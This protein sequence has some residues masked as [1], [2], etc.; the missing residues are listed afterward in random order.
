MA[1]PLSGKGA[2]V[3]A[4]GAALSFTGEAFTTVSANTVYQ[5]TN[6]AKRVWDRST[7]I[8]V[9][10]DAVTQAATLYTL[11]RLTG[12]ITFMADIGG[13]H[14]ITADGNYLPITQVAQGKAYTY[15]IRASNL[16]VT[17]F[18][19]TFVNRIQGCKDVSGS[20]NLWGIDTYYRDALIAGNPVVVEFWTDTT[21]VY[22]LRVW[23]LLNKEQ[24][25]TAITSAVDV[26]VSFAGATDADAREISG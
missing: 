10:K 15:H 19:D 26:A 20:V 5:I 24:V 21:S 22:D 8:T 16:N 4:S 7:T 1:G 18:G 14:T 23:A 25:Q 6:T 2:A 11:N 13:G 12:T 17:K 3:Y 9:K